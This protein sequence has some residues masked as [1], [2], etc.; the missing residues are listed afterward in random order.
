[1]KAHTRAPLFL[2]LPAALALLGPAACRPRAVE[3]LPREELFSLGI[4]KMDNQ[5]DLFQLRGQGYAQKIGLYMRDGLFYVANSSAGK[6]MELSSYGDLIFLLYDPRTNPPP[7]SFSSESS[8]SLAA[9]RKAVAY[10]LVS[11]G[12]L[13]VDSSK[14]L[15]LE[16]TVVQERQVTDSSL[17]VLL[18]RVVLRFDRH[19]KLLDFIGQEGVGGTPFPYIESLYVTGRDEL[20]VVSRTP[21]AWLVYWYTAGGSLQHQLTVENSNLPPLAAAAGVRPAATTSLGKLVPDLERRVLYAVLYYHDPQ[22]SASDPALG[23]LTRIYRIDAET[24]RYGEHVDV[25][26]DVDRQAAAG[27]QA[28]QLLPPSYELLGVNFRGE[29]FLLRREDTNLFRLLVLDRAGRALARR[30]LVMEDSELYLKVL[31]LSVEGIICALLAEEYRVRI[32]WWRSDRL[33]KEE[34]G[35]GG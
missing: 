12:E 33:L 19:G 9:T 22:A 27:S 6:V 4:G 17:G 20:V 1:M 18:S 13:A 10:P 29:F 26:A 31:N 32:V 23:Y 16:D 25:P 34:T 15:Y 28:G 3:E 8:D 7:V 2:A 5:V 14:R 24:G 11:I 35:E 30:N 21:R